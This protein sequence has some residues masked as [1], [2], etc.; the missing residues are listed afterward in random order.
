[1]TH[2]TL[3][4]PVTAAAVVVHGLCSSETGRHEHVP[5]ESA[6]DFYGTAGKTTVMGTSA[7]VAGLPLVDL[8]KSVLF[9]RRP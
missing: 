4:A 2:K 1:M 5:H 7:I 8:A 9:V 6:F 3:V